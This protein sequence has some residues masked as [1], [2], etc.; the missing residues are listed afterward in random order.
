MEGDGG[1][2]ELLVKEPPEADELL[3]NEGQF[4]LIM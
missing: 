1:F 4:S 3:E 2:K